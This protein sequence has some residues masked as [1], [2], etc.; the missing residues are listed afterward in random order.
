VFHLSLVL[1]TL[2]VVGALV[3]AQQPSGPRF[4]DIAEP[5]GLRF[6]HV[7]GAT[8]ELMYPELIGSGAA[9]F[10]Y[11]GDGD[12]DVFLIQGLND[13]RHAGVGSA[14]TPPVGS[15]T[16]RLFRNDLERPGGR[17]QFTDV[18][19]TAGVGFVGFGMGAAVGDVDN[20]GDL[21]LYVTAYGNNALYRNDGK[22]RFTNIT[23]AAGADDARW[24]SSAAFVDYD[25]DGHLDL[26]VGNYVDFTPAGNKPCL[27][28]AGQRDYCA[29]GAYRPLPD[30]LLRNRGNGTF[31]DVSEKAGISRAYGNALGIAVGDYDADGWP[32]IYVAN[33]ATPNQLWMNRRD[34]TFEE[35]GLLSGTAYNAAGRPEGSMG[36]ASGDYDRDGDDDLVVTNIVGETFVLY[37]NDGTGSFED[38]RAA[39][40]LAAPSAMMTGFGADWFDADNDGWLELFVA[41]GAV[42]I[43]PSL[44]ATANPFRQRNQL[45]TTGPA[46]AD[47]RRGTGAQM[48]SSGAA[49][50]AVT[51][52]EITSTAGPGLELLE[53]SRGAAFGDIDL[54]GRVD[55]LVTNNAGPVR[56]LRNVTADAGHWLRLRLEQPTTNRR[57]L[58]ASVRVDRADHPPI[59][60]RVR[61]GGS[62]L[63]ASD[64]RLYI[65][66]G[67]ESGAVTV[68]V[69]WPDGTVQTVP[70]LAVDR[71]HTIRRSR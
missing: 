69:T 10:D 7:N 18:T 67:Q 52:A 68:K 53:V 12:L 51:F 16:S 28:P 22:G 62:Y 6:V 55:V 47:R 66:L 40:G 50:Q 43:I 39:V 70:G 36:I 42:N 60:R 71:E 20:D 3:D 26:Y 29:P 46:T 2:A 56:L 9:L 38:R 30:R 27:E 19:A 1:G 32:D 48:S 15:P 63:S 58:G 44:R 25:R 64:D 49:A 34:G 45:F 5:S 54:D 37:E 61:S 24:S 65:G 57:A 59:V 23:D 17:L 4:E 31:E 41:N 8:G 35:M 33:D 14:A 13:V 11:D 21:D